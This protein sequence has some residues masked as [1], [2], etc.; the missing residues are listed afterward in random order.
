MFN[1][2][3]QAVATLIEMSRRRDLAKIDKAMDNQKRQAP[4]NFFS[5]GGNFANKNYGHNFTGRSKT[6]KANQRIERRLSRRRRMKPQA[7]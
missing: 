7:R 5:L 6:F 4:L 3:R 2:I 1:K